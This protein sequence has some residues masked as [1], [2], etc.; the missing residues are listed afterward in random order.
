M[1]IKNMKMLKLIL[2]SIL[3]I[4]TISVS[5]KRI[6]INYEP[7]GLIIKFT[8]DSLIVY[9]DTASILS[10]IRNDYQFQNFILK[11]T[12]ERINDTIIINDKEI[13]DK[14]DKCSHMFCSN[15]YA[16][17]LIQEN[18]AKIF[19]SN[20]NKINIIIEKKQIKMFLIF[21]YIGKKVYKNYETH[22]FL[23][24]LSFPDPRIAPCPCF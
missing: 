9:T 15:L 21:P 14:L 3:I 6:K 22:K 8:F 17:K 13:F 16:S 23:F 18:K 12:K 10:I 20:G 2:T 7:R 19:D 24:S 11:K 1:N 5:G 4:I